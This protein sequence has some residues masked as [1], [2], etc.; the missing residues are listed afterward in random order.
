MRV[1]ALLSY[2]Y[3][4]NIVLRWFGGFAMVDLTGQITCISF[5]FKIN[6][7]AAET[8][9]LLQRAFTS[10]SAMSQSVSRKDYRPLKAA[11]NF[12]Q[13]VSL[14]LPIADS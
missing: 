14:S 3:F 5:C 2:V 6:K 13:I 4:S 10:D 7:T 9:R 11:V 1:G 8:Y 12:E